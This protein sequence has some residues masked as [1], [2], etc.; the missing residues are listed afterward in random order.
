M[1]YRYR[2]MVVYIVGLFMTIIDGTIVNVAL[3]TL[4]RE[5]DVSST[6]IEWIAIAYLLAL[7]A[8]IPAAGWLGD[9]F[10]TKRMFLT[11]LTVFVVASGL[12]GAAPN[13]E[14]LI[15]FRVLQGLGAGLITPIGSAM[16]FRAFPLAERSTATVGVL[17]V[18]VVAPAI[19]PVLGGV[20]VDNIS[21]RWIFFVNL[22]IGA[23]AL[24]LA[25]IWLREEI[26]AAAGR[27][28]VRGLVL[29]ATGVSLLIYTLSTGPEQ[30][31][32]STQTIATGAIGVA[33]IVGLIVIELGL[34]QPLLQ[35]RLFAN[36]LFRVVNIS[37]AMVYAGFFGWI[38]V[39]PLYM[40]TLRG[41]SA[42]QSGLV[43]AP[44]ALAIFV[45]SNLLGKRVYRAVGPRRLMIAGSAATALFTGGF[46][47]VDLDTPLWMIA[48]GSALRGAAVGM[49]FV[50][51]QT[52]V[53]ATISNAETGRATALFNTQRQ[54]AYAAGVAIAASVI[55]AKVS[56]VGGDSAP[57]I[58]RLPAYQ[59]GFLAMGLIML[60]A[61]V[62]S[63]FV[64]DEDV[65]AT[66]GLA[67]APV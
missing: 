16:L 29:S 45:V 55:A 21:W 34:D 25:V 64:H 11:A 58:D 65:A 7:A 5:F 31:W 40:Q 67:P 48:C 39:L 47:F 42:T 43:Q 9:R 36:Q 38:F 6:D 63:W 33:A 27:L 37:A 57:A 52:A 13:L 62:T 54:I 4:A 12:C 23:L 66:R 26:Q 20:L 3:P 1:Q 32:L 8:M 17:S 53:Y 61:A 41:F 44:Q 24:T 46:V 22:P 15:T 60:P 49:V 28:D 59:W 2:V 19:G 30:G 50:S 14:A 35:L 51:I 18:A 10:G 56:S